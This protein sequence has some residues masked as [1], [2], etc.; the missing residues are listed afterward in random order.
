ME[1]CR[2]SAILKS[3]IEREVEMALKEYISEPFRL[4]PGD[5]RMLTPEEIA[6]LPGWPNDIVQEL[7]CESRITPKQAEERGISMGA[8]GYIWVDNVEPGTIIGNDD[9]ET[10]RIWNGINWVDDMPPLWIIDEDGARL[11]EP[12]LKPIDG[13]YVDPPVTWLDPQTGDFHSFS[14]LKDATDYLEA[15]FQKSLN[16]ANS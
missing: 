8:A 14:T 16:D 7:D 3:D 11:F 2:G 6:D 5:I 4:K 1:L 9:G 15:K 10:T 12:A 13:M